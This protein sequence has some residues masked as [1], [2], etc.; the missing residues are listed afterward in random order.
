MQPALLYA[1]CFL[2]QGKKQLKK[3]NKVTS[4]RSNVSLL[5]ASSHL[6]VSPTWHRAYLYR[7][8]NALRNALPEASDL[9]LP[10]W[11]ECASHGTDENPIPWFVTARQLPFPVDGRTDNPLF[12]Y[13]LQKA[14]ADNHTT[15]DVSRYTKPAGY[16]TVRYPLSGLVGNPKD[17][18]DTEVHNAKYLNH[19][20]NTKILNSNVKAW[21]DG[22][23]QITPDGD[24]DTRIP[25][26]YSVFSRFQICLEAPN[27]TVFSNKA[28]MAQYIV[29]HGGQPHYGVALEE[30][31]N[32]IHLALGGFYQKGVYNADPILGANGDMGENET[33]AFDPIFYLHHA[34]IDY[35]SW[36]W[37]LRH[38]CTA[39]GS[40]TVEA[41]KDGTFSMGDPTFP[42]GTALDTNS[43]LDPF[44]KPGGGFYASEDVTDIK[45]LEYSY[46]PGSLDVDPG[47][48]TPP[49]E[50]IASIA[51]VHN[52]SRA[53]YAGS[54]VIRTHVELPD[55]RN[56]EVGR[57]AVLSR[58]NVA[59]CRNC[60]DHLDENSFISIDKKTMETLKGNNDDKENI[61]FHVQIQ[62]RQFGGDELR[63]PVREPV[64]EFL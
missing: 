49:T 13:T 37:Q 54:F 15:T 25:D 19:E 31:H 8:E 45:K 17:K 10:F 11:D 46:G 40:L 60:Q 41:G 26:T 44:E 62:S 63:E 35:T 4:R 38:D 21:M 59:G 16:K 28:S 18:H 48:Y 30:P 7:L 39:A 23:V 32:A 64:V 9:A 47:R 36:Q 56:V 42:K 33:A 57:E 22:T 53:D 1:I 52:I 2:K 24:P 61:K 3:I 43:P 29:E 58:W 5:A 34:F 27:Y 12:S 14:L 50:P 6:G 51:R 55:G 20:D